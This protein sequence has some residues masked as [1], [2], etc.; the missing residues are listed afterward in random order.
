MPHVSKLHQGYEA[1]RLLEIYGRS[2]YR[3]KKR[4]WQDPIDLAAKLY[5][6]LNIA[7]KRA[8]IGVF[9]GNVHFVEKN[10]EK[11]LEVLVSERRRIEEKY[12]YIDPF[13]KLDLD[14]HKAILLFAVGDV[15]SAIRVMD[16]AITF[17]KLNKTFYLID[18]LYRLAA[19]YALMSKD[20]E[21]QERYIKKLKQYAEFS[22]ERDAMCRYPLF[23]IFSL[24][25]VKQDY[26]SALD[27]VNQYLEDPNFTLQLKPWLYL[28]KGKALH[29]LGEYKEAIYYLNKVEIPS[30]YHHPN[31][32]S[33]FYLKDTY[34]ALCNAKLGNQK[35]AL[36]AAKKAVEN[37]KSIPD[38]PHKDFSNNTYHDI[39]EKGK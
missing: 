27:I 6:Q 18:D 36:S 33:L 16:E 1:A 9:R 26:E 39:V 11:A 13:T 34:K 32:L 25:Y 22:D 8:S 15:A 35:E 7:P 12:T 20:V 14:Y 37:F 31:D 5:D 38:S 29:G 10:Y 19:Y 3:E 4:G 21:L 28:E 30:N 23:Y 24:N 2:L 17:S